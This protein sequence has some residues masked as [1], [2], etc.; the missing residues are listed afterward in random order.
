MGKRGPKPKTNS[1]GPRLPAVD[2]L[3]APDWVKRNPVAL[4]KW[5][6]VIAIRSELKLLTVADGE[7]LEAYV[8]FW[9]QSV[10]AR[11]AIEK[12][13]CIVKGYRGQ[14]VKNPRL[15][16]L[17]KSYDMVLKILAEFGMTPKSRNR[18]DVAQETDDRDDL[19]EVLRQLR[20]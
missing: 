5:H 20:D 7:L 16:I 18:V 11:K 2:S 15:P 9:A 4:E 1:Q 19:D 8:Y 10:K 12:E 14:P 17:N 6:Q 13:G 3:P